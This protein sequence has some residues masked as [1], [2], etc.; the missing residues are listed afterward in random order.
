MK[1]DDL[2]VFDYVMESD[3]IDEKVTVAYNMINHGGG[4][5]QA[6]GHAIYNADPI[7]TNKIKNTWPEYWE[8]YLH[9]EKQSNPHLKKSKVKA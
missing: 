6:L 5:V 3:N 4:F 1:N 7:N 8:Q 9:W 2:A